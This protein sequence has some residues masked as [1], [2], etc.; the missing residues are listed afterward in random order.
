MD[1]K[2]MNTLKYRLEE[3]DYQ[4]LIRID[5]PKLHQFIA[6]YVELCNPAKVFICTDSEEEIKY[7]RESAIRNGEES[8]LAMEG[9]T[10]HFDSFYDQGRDKENT[11]ILVSKGV[12]L[13][14]NIQTKDRD[15]AIIAIREILKD[16]MKGK[17]LYVRFFCL[18]PTNSEFSIPCVQLTDSAYVAHSE[19]LLYRAGYEEFVREGRDAHFFKFVHSQGEVDERKVCKNIDKRRIYIDI[20]DNIVYSTNTQ[21][22][23]NTIGLKKLAMRLAIKRGAEEGWLTEHMLI[24][25]IHGPNGRVTYF[26]GAFPSLCGKTSTAML[27]G[28]TI[29]GDDIAYLRKKDGVVRAVNVEKGMFGI[30][31]GVNSEDDPLQWKA[32]H[33]PNEIIFSNVLVTE[34]GGVHWI[35]KDGKVPPRGY[36]HSGDWTIG[37]KDTN[38]KEIPCSHPNA[39]FTLNLNI[40][41]NVDSKLN[42]P[43]GV[44]VA[45]MVYGGRDSDTSVPV[46][47]AFDWVHGIIT[48]G[49]SLESETTAATLGKE[50]VRE[51]NP[52]SNL[53][54]LS[55]PIGKYIQNNL[56]FGNDLKKPP[57]IFSVNYFLK[58]KIGKFLN[59]KIDK[60]VWYKWM[61]LRVHNEVEAI[62]TPTGRIPKYED[63]KRLFKKILN[64]DYT[65]DSYDKQFMI[66]I[67]ENLAKIER[68]KKIY[69]TQVFDTPK[70]VFEV[71]ESQRQRLEKASEKYGDYILPEEFGGVPK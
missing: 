48:K 53:D 46:E 41:D 30:I 55:I 64:K 20:E 54:F 34:D 71:L 8:K 65:Q 49:A 39:R 33:T 45:G 70:I 10:I 25:G 47:E 51:F 14:Q 4:K 50:G 7:I 12:N 6:E 63:I 68:I 18:G 59:E 69:K 13:G 21:Y 23:G 27:D 11:G 28:E 40:L 17:E 44:V 43:C 66:R 38:G 57:I 67:Q 2:T 16:I 3:K 35:G 15:E 1:E 37:K 5:N 56:D 26:T 61:E 31:Q 32:L 24:M 9:H 19:D 52:M 42:D 62:E 29:V 60:K 36:N 58:D 22:G